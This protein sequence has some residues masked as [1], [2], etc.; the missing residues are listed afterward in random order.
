MSEN[1][2]KMRVIVEVEDEAS[3]EMTVRDTLE[4]FKM[5]IEDVIK[6][7]RKLNK[8]VDERLEEQLEP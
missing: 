7:E 1:R 5:K 6:L 8:A 3:G 4:L 2:L